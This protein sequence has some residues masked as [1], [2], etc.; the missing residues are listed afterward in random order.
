MP[1]SQKHEPPDQRGD[2]EPD[3]H[4]YHG[5]CDRGDD[6]YHIARIRLQGKGQPEEI[7]RSQGCTAEELH[8]EVSP[9]ERRPGEGTSQDPW[10]PPGHISEGDRALHQQQDRACRQKRSSPPRL[11]PNPRIHDTEARAARQH[12]QRGNHGVLF[13][14]EA[15]DERHGGEPDQ[16][17]PGAHSL[18]TKGQGCR[19]HASH[20]EKIREGRGESGDPDVNLDSARM[21]GKYRARQNREFDPTEQEMCE[22]REEKGGCRANGEICGAV[23]AG[24]GTVTSVDQADQCDL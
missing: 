7:A 23:V 8:I 6:T 11:T 4:P 22:S 24:R 5:V 12:Q 2:G 18:G 20:D 13:G 16:S 10:P 1:P 9:D 19:E 14:C 15:Q 21:R 17:G 3:A